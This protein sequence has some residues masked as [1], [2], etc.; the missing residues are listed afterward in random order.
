MLDRGVHIRAAICYNVGMEKGFNFASV[1]DILDEL[2][3]GRP[4]VVTA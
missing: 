1:E 4:V 3:A 2:R